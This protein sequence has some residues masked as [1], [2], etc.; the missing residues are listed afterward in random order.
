[1]EI[2]PAWLVA[3]EQSEFPIAPALFDLL[4][5]RHAAAALKP[6]RGFAWA[7]LAR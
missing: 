7:W 5:A 6:P 3:F 4:L 1:M 2:D